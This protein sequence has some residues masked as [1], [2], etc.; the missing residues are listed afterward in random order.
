[1]RTELLLDANLS[2]KST[3]VLKRYFD[4]CFHVDCVNSLKVPAKD[5]EIWEYAKQHNLLM[6]IND[7]DFLNLLL[8]KGFPPKVILLKI[9][10]QS[11]TTIENLLI[12]T[13]TQIEELQIAEEYGI[14]EIIG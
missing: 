3:A 12:K 2:W 7:S 5:W 6:V 9:G 13:K 14:L 1:M 11:K 10:N 4:D 8:I